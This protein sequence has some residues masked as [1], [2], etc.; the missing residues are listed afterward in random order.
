MELEHDHE[1]RERVQPGHG[2]GPEPIGVESDDR[3]YRAPVVVGG[4]DMGKYLMPG[5]PLAGEHPPEE[6]RSIAATLK[7]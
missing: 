2:V 7:P 4:L 6:V 5:T 3:P 1:M